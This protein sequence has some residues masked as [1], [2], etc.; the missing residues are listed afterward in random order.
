LYSIGSPTSDAVEFF[1][2]FFRSQMVDRVVLCLCHNCLLSL[3]RSTSGAKVA[4]TAHSTQHTAQT[5]VPSVHPAVYKQL[6]LLLSINPMMVMLMCCAADSCETWPTRARPKH[7][8]ARQ[9]AQLRR[10][11]II[12]SCQFRGLQPAACPQ[13][14]RFD[15]SLEIFHFSEE[16][17]CARYTS[18]THHL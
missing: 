6:P 5:T 3:E 10:V 14:G 17:T 18:H 1:H 11:R 9:I 4:L 8:E 2:K 13:L 7:P 12:L 16:I 15:R